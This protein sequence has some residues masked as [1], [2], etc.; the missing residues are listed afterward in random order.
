[1]RLGYKE[2]KS[3]IDQQ[4]FANTMIANKQ[5]SDHKK[6]IEKFRQIS[7]AVEHQQNQAVRNPGLGALLKKKMR[8]LKSQEKGFNKEKERFIAIPEKEKPMNLFFE[9]TGKINSQKQIL[10]HNLKEF[11][12]KNGNIIKQVKL[13]LKATDKVVIIGDNGVGKTTLINF[14]NKTLKEEHI[15]YGYISQNYMDI[16]EPNLNVLEFL[17]KHQDKH[18]I[19]RIRQILGA[20]GLKRDEMLYPNK[21]LSEGTKL[22]VLLLL[23]VCQDVEV[24]VL[25]E[26]T[27]NISPL[28]QDELYALFASFRR[29]IIAVTH[30]RAFMEA[31]FDDV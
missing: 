8:S 15:K 19:T 7:Q 30:D 26:P 23:L 6:R 17:L 13:T 22:K 12:L 28:N 10:N 4:F 14:I 9:E 16:L 31:V 18:Q 25:D 24:I 11:E 3:F 29:C 2:Y 27:R 20:L 1:M 21:N 5:R